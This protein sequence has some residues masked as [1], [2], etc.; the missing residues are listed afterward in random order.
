MFDDE[1]QQGHVLVGQAMGHVRSAQGARTPRTP[2]Q[3]LQMA[4]RAVGRAFQLF[5]RSGLTKQ[6]AIDRIVALSQTLG[7]LE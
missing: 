6:Q 4:G 5:V 2:E 7:S 3:N 1:W